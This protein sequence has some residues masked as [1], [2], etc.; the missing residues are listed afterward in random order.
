MI[1]AAADRAP[2]LALDFQIAGAAL[3]YPFSYDADEAP[4]LAPAI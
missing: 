1:P 3:I 2:Q 4:D